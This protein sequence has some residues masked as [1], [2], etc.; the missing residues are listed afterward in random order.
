[1]KHLYR[2]R[3]FLRPTLRA[4]LVR[5]RD[6]RTEQRMRLQRLRLELRM[7]LATDKMGMVRQFDHLD[8]S[9][10][11][12]RTGNSQPRRHHRLF[13]FAI[14]LIAMAVALAD[15]QLAINLLRQR[16]GLDLT[17]PRSQAHGAAKF[18]DAAQ[19]AELVD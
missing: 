13:V 9:P 19:L 10:V 4:E 8:V 11:G 5:C 3:L 2:R 17:G 14:E 16:V 15:L 6:E 7:E 1:M 18:L 12:R